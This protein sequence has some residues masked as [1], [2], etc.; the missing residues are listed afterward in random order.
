MLSPL[1]AHWRAKAIRRCGPSAL[2]AAR[3]AKYCILI[4][5]FVTMSAWPVVDWSKGVWYNETGPGAFGRGVALVKAFLSTCC[6]RDGL[7]EPRPR[8]PA[9]YL[10]NCRADEHRLGQHFVPLPRGRRRGT[11]CGFSSCVAEAGRGREDESCVTRM[12]TARPQG[13][14]RGGVRFGAACLRVDA[15]RGD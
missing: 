13:S 11:A 9:S 8:L 14:G 3:E 12:Q 4:P 1:A 5:A 7:P 10:R 6:D 15:L 2:P